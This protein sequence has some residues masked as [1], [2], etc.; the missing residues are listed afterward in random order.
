MAA[1]GRLKLVPLPVSQVLP[2]FK[3]YSQVA[4]ATKPPTSITPLL[5][6]WSVGLAPVSWCS[7]RVGTSVAVTV[8]AG[9]T[10]VA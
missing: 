10:A 9:T 1:L 2:P 4:P 8:P 6:M 3:L 7:A 5:V